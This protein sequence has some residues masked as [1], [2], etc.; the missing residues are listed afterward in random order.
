[1][2]VGVMVTTPLTSAQPAS[3][4]SVRAAMRGGPVGQAKDMRRE[5]VA[6]DEIDVA[7]AELVEDVPVRLDRRD[8]E[9]RRGEQQ[10]RRRDTRRRSLVTAE[11]TARR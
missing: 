5:D 2:P 10:H 1:M 7:V 3:A 11:N 8:L 6:G 4:R 9:G